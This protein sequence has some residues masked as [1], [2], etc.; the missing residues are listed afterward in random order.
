[1]TDKPATP[2]PVINW[3]CK[4]CGTI[5]SGVIDD[6]DC[7]LKAATLRIGELERERD[8]YR[9]L[10]A[11][12]AVIH[13]VEAELGKLTLCTIDEY[14]RLKNTEAALAERDAQ[15]VSLANESAE[16]LGII[17]AFVIAA[18]GLDSLDQM[19]DDYAAALDAFLNAVEK[20]RP[21]TEKA[22]LAKHEAAIDAEKK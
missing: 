9:E 3:T 15:N 19:D 11:S 5:H 10:A 8:A 17:D 16:L 22:L 1:M 13:K 20:A 7:Q 14:K 6:L 12:N 2:T 21:Y 4:D 18:D